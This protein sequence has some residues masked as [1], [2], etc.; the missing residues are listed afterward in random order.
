MC[1]LLLIRLL[2]L[3]FLLL[4]VVVRWQKLSQQ[5]GNFLKSFHDPTKC[6]HAIRRE[7]DYHTIEMYS[8]IIYIRQHLKKRVLYMPLYIQRITI[9]MWRTFACNVP[10]KTKC[11]NKWLCIRRLP[12]IKKICLTACIYVKIISSYTRALSLMLNTSIENYV[13]A[14]LV[15][16]YLVGESG[17]GDVHQWMKL[18]LLNGHTQALIVFA[19]GNTLIVLL[20]WTQLQKYL[21]T[22]NFDVVYVPRLHSKIFSHLMNEFRSSSFASI[23]NVSFY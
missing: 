12:Y 2:L 4:L 8:I 20:N 9:Y 22:R 14:F 3:L 19:C 18:T 10:N 6:I 17:M 1:I 11:A 5:N 16:N 21:N 7:Y 15:A 23:L 13:L